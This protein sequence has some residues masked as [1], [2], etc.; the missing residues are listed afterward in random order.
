MRS[1]INSTIQASKNVNKKTKEVLKLKDAERKAAKGK[2]EY[3]EDADEEWGG[4]GGAEEEDPDKPKKY[5]KEKEKAKPEEA[6]DPFAKQPKKKPVVSDET[7]ATEALPRGRTGK[8]EFSTASQTRSIND[9]V[10]APPTLAKPARKGLLAKALSSASDGTDKKGI[11]GGEMRI[12]GMEEPVGRSRLP[13]DPVMKALL[14]RERERAVKT[15]REL[16]EKKLAE[17]TG[18]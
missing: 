17:K 18:Q 16:K 14:D 12:A 1:S 10:L 7:T 2:T 13:V 6:R 4:I 3:A 11:L 9:I 15:Y 8:T 5:G